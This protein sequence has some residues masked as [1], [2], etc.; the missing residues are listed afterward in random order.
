[1]KIIYIG[2]ILLSFQN[3][4]VKLKEYWQSKNC[5]IL[6]P[7]DL[8]VGAGTFH[9]ATFFKAIG[10]NS[11]NA[12]YAQPCRRPT[13]GRYGNNPNRLQ[14]YYQFQVIMKP[15]PKKIQDMYIDSLN[16]LGINCLL[17]DIRFV[18][19]NWASPTLG[20]WGMGWEIWINGMEISQFTYFQQVGGIECNPV[21]V[22]ITYGIER[23]AMY[24]QEVD[25][26]YDLVW[27]DI[28]NKK[29]FY[30][31]IFIENEIQ[32]SRYNFEEANTN[33][34]FQEFDL[35]I[36]EVKKLLNK[37]LFLP[38]Y[39]IVIK[40][41]HIFNLLDSRNA[42]SVNERQKYILR[43]RKLS[44]DIAQLYYQKEQN[45]DFIDYKKKE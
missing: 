11:W 30:R 27:G 39:E 42:I 29:I 17:N 16:A 18:E 5:L 32:M 6:E 31:D 8:P 44:L 40:I 2:F 25:N 19:D 33:T 24:L 20:A 3:I 21:S 45:N 13:D 1:M 38:A 37:L 23:L 36:L 7:F 41:S 22:E 15:S 35:Y 12:A 43:I 4:I 14:H 28:L 10:T 26:V 34:L 9:P